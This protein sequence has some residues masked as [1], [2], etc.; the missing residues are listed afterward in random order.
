MGEIRTRRVS[1]SWVDEWG[2]RG[3]HSPVTPHRRLAEPLLEFVPSADG[4]SRAVVVRRE[5]DWTVG[6][7]AGKEAAGK[8]G[9]D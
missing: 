8:Y 4:S 9:R 3:R 6:G 1:R 5:E 2:P 7:L